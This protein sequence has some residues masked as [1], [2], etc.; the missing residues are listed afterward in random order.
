MGASP[1]IT[2][3]L[4]T[5]ERVATREI[6]F[7]AD[8]ADD[9]VERARIVS[10]AATV[11]AATENPVINLPLTAASVKLADGNA[12]VASVPCAAVA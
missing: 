1:G 5:G 4:R 7:K 9:L 3:D 8:I 2:H 11:P 10:E 6:S 12:L